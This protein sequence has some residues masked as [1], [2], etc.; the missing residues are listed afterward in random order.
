MGEWLVDGKLVCE[1]PLL[2]KSSIGD[3][4]PAS[5]HG[6]AGWPKG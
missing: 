6:I 1:T 5:N 2:R 4:V 3:N